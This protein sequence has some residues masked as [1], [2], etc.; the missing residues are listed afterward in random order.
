[1]KNKKGFTLVE[2]LVVIAIIGLLSTIAFIS[3]N[4]ARGKARDAKRISDV[5]QIQSALELYYNDQGTPQYPDLDTPAV[6]TSV[7]L[8]SV[9]VAQVPIAPTPEDG[10]CTS[11]QNGYR[12][13]SQISQSN[14]GDCDAA[15][16]G[17]CGWYQMSFCVG[18]PSGSITAAGCVVATPAGIVSGTCLP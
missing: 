5:R 13:A 2:L 16:L 7:Q 4:R 17:N 15:T 11:A 14:T 12:Y 1:M 8:S 10:T 6:I 3:L 9:Y 18:S